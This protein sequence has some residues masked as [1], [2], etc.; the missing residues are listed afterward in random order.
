MSMY[1]TVEFDC[2]YCGHEL[3]MQSYAGPCVQNGYTLNTAPASILIDLAGDTIKCDGCTK[4]VM[5]YAVTTAQ[6][7]T[8]TSQRHFSWKQIKEMGR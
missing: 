1:D 8:P 5:V 3:S 6:V 4:I 2:P 7:V